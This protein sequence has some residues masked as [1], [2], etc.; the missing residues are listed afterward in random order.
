MPTDKLQTVPAEGAAGVTARGET[1]PSGVPA[2]EATYYTDPLCPWSWAFEAQWRR[3]RFEY[4]DRLAWR[5]VMGGMVA[6]W[7]S[8]RDPVNAVHNP[9]QMGLQC[10]QVRQLTGAPLDERVWHDDPPSSSYPACLA[11]KA[12]ERQS[13]EAGEAYLRRVRET[14]MLAG[15]NIARAEVLVEL[16]EELAGDPSLE[17]VFDACRFREDLLGADVRDAFQD[18]IREVGYQNIIRFPTLVLRAGDGPGIVL[19]GYRPYENIL[20]AVN[21][22]APDASPRHGRGETDLVNYVT[23][24][25]RAAENEVAE[26]LGVEL[27]AARR[28]LD[29]AVASGAL[30]REG[31][32]P[33]CYRVPHP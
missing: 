1:A 5:Y 30:A 22:I 13:R 28:L 19:A 7:R 25:K 3:L 23:R 16:A 21:R 10:Y 26:S 2:L 6:D 33:G 20:R 31:A 27:P 8:Y 11:V 24:W 12:A 32:L 4:G 15:R 14:V 17:S 29:E 18:D 9:G